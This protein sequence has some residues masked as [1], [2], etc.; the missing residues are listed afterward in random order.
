MPTEDVPPAVSTLLGGAAGS[1][2][3]LMVM[4]ALVVRT[5]M[6][7]QGA[8]KTAKTYT[9]FGHAMR[10]MVREEGIGAFY[11]GMG[12]N[13][14]FTPL[15]RGLFMTGAEASKRVIGDDSAL[16]NFAAGMNAQLLSSI[17]Y[18]PRDVIVERCAIDGQ[19]KS[20]IGSTASTGAALRTIFSTEGARGFYRA[21]LPHQLVWVPFN[22][23]FFAA[24]GKCN[25]VEEAA[26]ID[27]SSCTN[28]GPNNSSLRPRTH[29]D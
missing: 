5:R 25:A 12:M 7:I 14:A 22:G 1:L 4:P 15:A 28:A 26:G 21:F 11:K 29:H 17:A 27:T 23:L 9:S 18:V 3:E 6:M 8:D 24:L 10:T 16:K 2:A 19:L 13:M 20:Q